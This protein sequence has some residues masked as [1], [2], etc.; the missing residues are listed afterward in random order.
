MEAR[1]G[2]SPW[3]VVYALSPNH[4]SHQNLLIQHHLIVH[5]VPRCHHRRRLHL[6]DDRSPVLT[7]TAVHVAYQVTTELETAIIHLRCESILIAD[8]DS[9]VAQY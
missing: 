8:D 3:L 4:L 9:W 7:V 2:L 6:R 5:L 1:H